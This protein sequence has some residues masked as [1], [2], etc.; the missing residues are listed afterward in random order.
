MA[1]AE[2][3]L[4]RMARDL[5]EAEEELDARDEEAARRGRE[6]GAESRETTRRLAEKKAPLGRWFQG[7]VPPPSP[8]AGPPGGSGSAPTHPVFSKVRN[9]RHAEVSDVGVRGGSRTRGTRAGTRP[10]RAAQ[11]NRKRTSR[12]RAP[13]ADLDA[14]NEQGQTAMHFA[15]AYGYR[16]LA[17]YLVRKGANPMVVVG[18]GSGPTRGSGR[19]GCCDDPPAS[20]RVGQGVCLSTGRTA[21]ARA[22]SFRHGVS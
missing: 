11:N 21:R 7:P 19:T 20:R 17:E 10:G 8:L 14:Q 1:K 15:H 6:G 13:G 18:T 22:S 2:A 16:E 5:A 3:K 9:N 12:R 4:E